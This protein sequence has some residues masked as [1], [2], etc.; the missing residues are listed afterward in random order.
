M[1]VTWLGQ[2]G[3]LFVSNNFRLVVDPY[4]SDVLKDRFPRLIPFPVSLEELRPDALFITHDHIDHFDPEGVPQII[5]AYP[6]CRCFAPQQAFEHF[7][8]VGADP[9][10]VELMTIGKTVEAGPFKVS[11]VF[12]SH[13]DP[14]ACG[15]ILEA[16]GR[17]VWLS[18]D[19]LFDEALF[20]PQ[21]ANLTD[22]FICINGKLG[23]MNCSEAVECVR[24]LAPRRA[25]PMHIG[26]FAANTAD[27]AEFVDACRAM[28][29]DSFA[30]SAG[31]E[32]EL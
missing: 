26:L 29:I 3:F 9:A 19:T 8:A 1:K 30:M 28:N 6:Q 11:A 13:S 21:M 23:N 27:P 4:M 7:A 17:K 25:L 24:R 32:F 5:A 22:V 18:G 31:V 12:A 20:A 15:Y 16:D 2:G 14:T 10:N